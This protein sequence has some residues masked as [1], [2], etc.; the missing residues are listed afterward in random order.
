MARSLSDDPVKLRNELLGLRRRAHA[1]E[2][3]L[4]EMKR[5]VEGEPHVPTGE[6]LHRMVEQAKACV[7][8][9]LHELPDVVEPNEWGEF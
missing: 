7:G 1:I 6:E 3:K 8:A 9:P 5:S 2:K 4:T